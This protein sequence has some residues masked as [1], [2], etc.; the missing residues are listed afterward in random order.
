[1]P[2]C[3]LCAAVADT[4]RSA[5]LIS[6]EPSAA[7]AAAL[8]VTTR[9]TR[10]AVS[11]AAAQSRAGLCD[12][13]VAEQQAAD[14]MSTSAQTG[15]EAIRLPARHT[16]TRTHTPT[17]PPEAPSAADA[18]PVKAVDVG[19]PRPGPVGTLQVPQHLNQCL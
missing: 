1:M 10:K 19:V 17:N 12:V 2:R 7:L 6:S 3:S 11:V 9:R 18:T 15:A 14:N 13:V 4:A 16:H 5:A 8:S